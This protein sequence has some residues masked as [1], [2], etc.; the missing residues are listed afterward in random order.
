M[1]EQ[2]RF[3]ELGVETRLS[4]V[5]RRTLSNTLRYIRVAYLG[6]ENAPLAFEMLNALRPGNNLTWNLVVQQ[7]LSNGLNVSLNYDGRKPQGM[8][9]I[10]SGR[11][12]VSVLF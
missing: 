1:A 10:H 2:A 9:M 12:Q 8:A 11:M 6:N 7:K 5:G 4:Q 3:H